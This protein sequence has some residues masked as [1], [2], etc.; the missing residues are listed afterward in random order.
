M[1]EWLCGGEALADLKYRSGDLSLLNIA[2][3]HHWPDPTLDDPKAAYQ[4]AKKQPLGERLAF[5]AMFFLGVS[6]YLPPTFEYR[7]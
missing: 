5:N 7:R 6:F 3:V 1:P 4:E 2:H